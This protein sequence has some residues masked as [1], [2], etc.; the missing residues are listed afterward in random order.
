VHIASFQVKNYKSFRETPEIDLAPG[1][2]V[3]VG[4]NNV[5]KTALVEALGLRFT[6]S[7]HRSLRTAPNRLTPISNVSAVVVRLELAREELVELIR[8]I[9]DFYVPTDAGTAQDAAVA[10]SETLREP[11]HLLLTSWHNGGVGSA[12]LAGIP[13]RLITGHSANLRI[14]D[15]GAVEH[16]REPIVGV[17]E[18]ARFEFPLAQRIR[19]ERIYAFNAER[20]RVGLSAFGTSSI[21][22]PDATNLP[23]VLATLQGRNPRRFARLV[24]LLCTVFPSVKGVGVQPRDGNNVE[25]LIW[26]VEPDTERDDLA[27]RLAESGTGIG[28]VL[29]MLYVVVNADFPQ[30]ILIDEPQSFLH[31]GAVRKLIEIFKQH[32]QHQFIITTHSPMALTTADP[33]MLFRPRL[34]Q[35]E[36]IIDRLDITEARDLR[37]VLADVGARLSDVFGADNILWVE[38]RTEELCFPK[39][40]ERLM[41]SPMLGTAIVGVLHTAD[42]EAR[43]SEATVEL[44]NRLSAGRGLLPPAVGFIF[45]LEG[46][47]DRDRADLERRGNVFFLPRRMYENYLLNPAPIAAVAASIPGF[48]NEPLTEAEVLAWLDLHRW[49]ATF[50]DPLP[51]ERTDVV[52]LRNVRGDRLLGDLFAQLSE[53]RVQ[54]D[55]VRHGVALTDWLLEHAPGELREVG[56]LIARALVPRAA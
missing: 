22:R 4:Q 17:T 9:G 6:S 32:P 18:N 49:N 42:F 12:R 11:K 14:T 5:G 15:A 13:E 56:E 33:A 53:Q 21:L 46:R 44:Y 47:N 35:G 39:I 52:W 55:K 16:V 8:R 54:Y 51:A 34:D 38:G 23:E 7:P 43:R 31:P 50:F 25:V 2:N 26:T 48:R 37:L 29:A 27:V 28:Q 10:F 30:T 3:I 41:E 1:F 45:D 24:S 40:T 36:T 19:D 20:L